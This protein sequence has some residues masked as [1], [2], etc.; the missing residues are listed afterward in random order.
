MNVVSKTFR[1]IREGNVKQLLSRANGLHDNCRLQSSG[2]SGESLRSESVLRQYTIKCTCSMSHRSETE[3]RDG[4]VEETAITGAAKNT[5]TSKR[6]NSR[7]FNLI[8]MEDTHYNN[9]EFKQHFFPFF[10]PISQVFVTS[11]CRR[12]FQHFTGMKRM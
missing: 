7:L 5:L 3:K 10:P 6:S 2:G 12:D 9:V 4:T 11:L 8:L 1:T